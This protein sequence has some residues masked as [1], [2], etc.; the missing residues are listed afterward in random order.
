M[1]RSTIIILIALILGLIFPRVSNAA[2]DCVPIYGGGETCLSQSKIKVDKKVAS[3][4]TKNFVDNLSSS[5]PKYKAGDEINFQLTITNQGKETLS[6]IEIAD[7][8]PNLIT[9]TSGPGAFDSKKRTLTFKLSSL[10]QNETRKFIVKGTIDNVL[11]SICVVNY[12]RVKSD[13]V[14]ADDSSKFCLEKSF[15]ED[16]GASGR[17]KG[18]FPVMEAP[19]DLNQ[20]PA[21]GPEMLP[22]ISL[23]PIGLTGIYLRKKSQPKA[24]QPRAENKA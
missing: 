9:Y 7:N 8:L 17:T 6:E 12:V 13:K 16:D 10:K 11:K 5:D 19:K 3:P 21:T 14:V 20:T 15:C 23:V 18:G 4:T 22:L 1:S 24:D 2:G